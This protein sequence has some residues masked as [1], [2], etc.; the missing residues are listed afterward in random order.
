MIRWSTYALVTGMFLTA[1]GDA[2]PAPSDEATD[3]TTPAADASVKTDEAAQKAAPSEPAKVEPI[4]A[5]WS[6]GQA[7]SAETLVS[8]CS[9]KLEVMADEKGVAP[10]EGYGAD[11][12]VSFTSSSGMMEEHIKGSWT[13]KEGTLTLNAKKQVINGKG[14]T[15]SDQDV[16]AKYSAFQKYGDLLA[17]QRD[18]KWYA[19]KDCGASNWTDATNLNWD[20][21]VIQVIDATGGADQVKAAVTALTGAGAVVLPGEAAKNP[22]KGAQILTRNAGDYNSLKAALEGAGFGPVE[23]KPWPE[24]PA[25]VV[26]A[27]GPNA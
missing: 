11:G 7:V 23:I 20:E 22:R 9:Y 24:S 26:V 5:D 10:T 6:Q 15:I 25:P 16:S 12:T 19:T 8:M 1:C 2:P 3:G 27:V 18:G 14:D 13:L 17:G 4:A 21:S